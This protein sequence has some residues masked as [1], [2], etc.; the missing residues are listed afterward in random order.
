[1]EATRYS[2]G[3]PQLSYLLTFV[4]ASGCMEQRSRLSDVVCRLGRWYRGE[5]GPCGLRD[6]L[7]SLLGRLGH[8]WPVELAHV[9]AFGARKYARGN[10]LL[11]RP[12]SETCDSLL[13]HLRALE[14]GV[15]LDA[16]SGLS[17]VGHAAWNALYLL[18]CVNTMPEFDDRIRPPASEGG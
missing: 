1:M 4:G 15:A 6:S 13:R 5:E 8:D 3:K 7:R 14:D 18:H 10:Y 9:A 12:W 16:E 11:G 2:G 17:H